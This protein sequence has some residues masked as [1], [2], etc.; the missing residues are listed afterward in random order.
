MTDPHI[1]QYNGFRVESKTSD[2]EQGKVDYAV[3][4]DNSQG[5]VFYENGNFF[6]FNRGTSC[7]LC[8]T[9]ITDGKTPAKTIDAKNGDIL[10][11]AQNGT[12]V[13]QAANIRLVGIDG[14]EGE[15]SI[16]GSKT[17]VMNAPTVTAQGTNVT[18]AAGQNANVTGTTTS[19]SANTQAE[20]QSGIDSDKSSLLGK[21][22][23]AITKFKK[24]FESICAN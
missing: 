4:T 22:L 20:V 19:V 3:T 17:I 7:E 10:I 2:K 16:Q 1:R 5:L 23:D 24:F 11:R 14:K 21:I 13:L 15:I 9:S 18:M 8:G 12:I 6:T